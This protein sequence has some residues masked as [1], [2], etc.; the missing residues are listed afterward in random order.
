MAAAASVRTQSTV[1]GLT[2]AQVLSVNSIQRVEMK[3]SFK[4]IPCYPSTH[5]LETIEHSEPGS[6]QN[7]LAKEERKSSAAPRQP[8]HKD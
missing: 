4:N 2:L 1:L 8:T 5:T 6:Q 7:Q 3:I